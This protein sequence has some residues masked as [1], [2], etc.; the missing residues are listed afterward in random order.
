[1]NIFK[2]IRKR[3]I[4]FLD[5]RDESQECFVNK[6]D[7]IIAIVDMLSLPQYLFYSL[8]YT[9]TNDVDFGKKDYFRLYPKKA[10]G[11]TF[12]CEKDYESDDKGWT[13]KDALESNKIDEIK[14]PYIEYLDE[15]NELNYDLC[16][17]KVDSFK[18]IENKERIE[19]IIDK[20][21]VG[22]IYSEELNFHEVSY[23]DGL[24]NLK[25][26]FKK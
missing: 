6:N 5:Y 19:I 7:E 9:K 16:V 23:E 13:L 26:S 1:M 12:E 3:Y 22:S 18:L 10:K 21:S 17:R 15:N 2:A 14:V 25:F 20:S 8:F 24:L 4:D 11:L